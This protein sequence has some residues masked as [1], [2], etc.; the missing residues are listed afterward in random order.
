MSKASWTVILFMAMSNV[1]IAVSELNCEKVYLNTIGDESD[2]L[3]SGTFGLIA[4]NFTYTT[5]T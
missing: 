5:G 4:Q 3:G 2:R 1:Y